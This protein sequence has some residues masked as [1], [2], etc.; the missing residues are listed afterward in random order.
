MQPVLCVL[1]GRLRLLLDDHEFFLSQGEAAEFD[2]R[3]GQWMG[4]A[5]HQP[6]DILVLF[7]AQ[8]ERVH[9]RAR[10]VGATG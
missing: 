6:V 10:A 2:T 3:I 9:L 5:N 8:G 4:A 7:G 1:A